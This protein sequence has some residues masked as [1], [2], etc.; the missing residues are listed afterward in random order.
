[1]NE[2]VM[3]D[4]S[5]VNG[6]NE[7]PMPPKKPQSVGPV[8]GISIIV[9]VLL[10]GGLYFWGEQVKKQEREEAVQKAQEI[11]SAPDNKT[12][13]LN[14]QSSSDAASSIEADL[15]ATDLNNLDEGTSQADGELQ[16]Q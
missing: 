1:M 8:I 9:L 3:S 7:A 11:E 10:V 13:R 14:T 5:D 16:L 15:S 6:G 12:D 4:M 2:P